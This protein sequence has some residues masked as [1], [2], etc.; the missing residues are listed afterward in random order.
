MF[1]PKANLK[2]DKDE[3]SN[4]LIERVQKLI[5]EEILNGSENFALVAT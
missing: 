4:P 2:Q 3:K 1:T 5:F